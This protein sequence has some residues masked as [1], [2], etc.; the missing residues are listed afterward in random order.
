MRSPNPIVKN[1]E[2]KR[3]KKRIADLRRRLSKS[4]VTK[5]CTN[6]IMINIMAT[7]VKS[8]I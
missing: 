2:M 3:N 5:K 1:L 7:L 4:F 6:N 8:Q